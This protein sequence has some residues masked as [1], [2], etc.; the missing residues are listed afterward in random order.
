[1]KINIL[2]GALGAEISNFNLNTITHDNFK[3]LNDLLLEHK[4]I[5]FRDQNI[6]PEELMYLGS[7]FGTVEEHAY[8]KGLENF[9]QIT[10]IV[11]ALTILVICGK[12]SNPFTYACSS[13]VPNK[14]P[15]YINSSGVIF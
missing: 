15:R 5:F 4:V 10:R 7:L 3:N 12:F 8:V 13:T 2:S 9:P 1:M 14:D 11:K 6:T